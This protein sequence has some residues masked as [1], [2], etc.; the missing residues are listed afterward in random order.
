VVAD[1]AQCGCERQLGQGC[2]QRSQR[3]PDSG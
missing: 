3:W 1:A 2:P